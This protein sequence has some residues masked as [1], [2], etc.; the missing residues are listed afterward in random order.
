MIRRLED[1]HA[2]ML[3]FADAL[4]EAIPE[5]EAL[6][7]GQSFDQAK[8]DAVTDAANTMSPVARDVC[9]PNVIN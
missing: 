9:D 1:E 4:E 6:V 8:L 5:M 3:A 2:Y 7:V